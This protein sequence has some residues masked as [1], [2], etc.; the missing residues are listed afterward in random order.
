[1]I[2]ALTTLDSSGVALAT[3]KALTEENV[4][5]KQRLES[6]QIQM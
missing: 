1:M 2:V 3:I 4:S 6:R 5:L